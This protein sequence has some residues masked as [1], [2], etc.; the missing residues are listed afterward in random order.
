MK[1]FECMIGDPLGIHARTV[2]AM[3]VEAGKHACS[4]VI[5]AGEGSAEVT[6]MIGVMGLSIGY[7]QTV[8]LEFE[9]AQEDA[10]VEGLRSVLTASWEEK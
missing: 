6:D 9:G 1:K 2:A 5:R 8:T 4:I 3:A 7:G 10:A